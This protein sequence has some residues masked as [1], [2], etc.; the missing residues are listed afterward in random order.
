MYA[1]QNTFNSVKQKMKFL[2]SR[3][4]PTILIS[5]I[6]WVRDLMAIMW[7]VNSAAGVRFP[8]CARSPML[9]LSKSANLNQSLNG[10]LLLD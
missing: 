9:T 2:R 1:Y 5:Y 7:Y 6:M 8:A 4:Q 10:G 3:N